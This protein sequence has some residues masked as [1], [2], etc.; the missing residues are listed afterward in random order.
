MI[1]D[2][3]IKYLLLN[4]VYF[5]R[6]ENIGGFTDASKELESL[7]KSLFS[8]IDKTSFDVSAV[9]CNN[10]NIEF[11]SND[12]VEFQVTTN[13]DFTTKCSDTITDFI[14]KKSSNKL[15]IVYYKEL[16]KKEQIKKNEFLNT[17]SFLEIVDAADLSRLIA[18]CS[19]SEIS[20]IVNE[21]QNFLPLKIEEIDMNACLQKQSVC[22]DF[23]ERTFN[24]L[25]HSRINTEDIVQTNNSVIIGDASTGKTELLKYINNLSVEKNRSTFFYKLKNYSGTKLKDILPNAVY[26]SFDPLIL[27]DGYDE[28]KQEYIDTF[29]SELN[30]LASKYPNFQIIISSRKNFCDKSFSP[31]DEFSFLYIEDIDDKEITQYFNKKLEKDGDKYIELCKTLNVYELLYNPFYLTRIVSAIKTNSTI[32]NRAELMELVF[33]NDYD[34]FK[35]SEN[36]KK[37]DLL[38]KLM[39]FA[40][41]LV[42][43]RTMSVPADAY[44]DINADDFKDFAWLLFEDGN[45]SFVHNNFKEYLMAKKMATYSFGKIKNIIS[46]RLDKIY[47]KPEYTSILS[48][49]LSIDSG[50]KLH[51]YILNYGKHIILDLEISSLSSEEKYKVITG[52]YGEYEKKKSWPDASFYKSYSL[53]K[54]CNTKRII[55]FLISK[56]DIANHRTTVVFTLEILKNINCWFG[57]KNTLERNIYKMLNSKIE[58]ITM[59][60]SLIYFWAKLNPGIE[61]V[62][63]IYLMYRTHEKSS[64]RASA[65]YLLKEYKLGNKFVEEMLN[66]I[67][68]TIPIA[69]A[70]G[71]K[72][73][74]IIDIGE[75]MYLEQAIDL[76]DDKQAVVKLLDFLIKNEKS[77]TFHSLTEHIFNALKN[78]KQIDEEIIEKIYVLY[79]QVEFYDS[80]NVKQCIMDWLT[81]NELIENIIKRIVKD[82]ELIEYKKYAMLSCLYSEK[83]NNIYLD[84]FKQNLLNDPNR[85]MLEL[86]SIN[87]DWSSL[88]NVLTL[89]DIKVEEINKKANNNAYEERVKENFNYL[90]DKSIL[91]D[92]IHGIYVQSGK[93]TLNR[94]D[95]MSIRC[96]E[97]FDDR[98]PIYLCKLFDE[99]SI[100]ETEVF[101][102]ICDDW[103]IYCA[104]ELLQQSKFIVVSN[105]QKEFISNWVFDKVK[106]F[107]F[108]DSIS[109]NN[110][111]CSTSFDAI[112]CDYFIRKLDLAVDKNIL[113]QMICFVWDIRDENDFSQIEFIKQKIGESELKDALRL[114][115]ERGNLQSYPLQNRINYCINND[116]D[117]LLNCIINKLATIKKSDKYSY[118]Y[119]AC[120]N[121]LEKFNYLELIIPYYINFPIELKLYV[122]N[123]FY[124]NNNKAI[125]DIAKNDFKKNTCYSFMRTLMQFGDEDA[126][127]YYIKYVKKNKCLYPKMEYPYPSVK[128]YN[129][130]SNLKLLFKLLPL[131]YRFEDDENSVRNDIMYCFEKICCNSNIFTMRKFLRKINLFIKHSKYKN[132]NYLHYY[133]DGIILSYINS[134]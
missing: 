106:K 108:E 124:K 60:S 128:S 79:K 111:K 20:A 31:F 39:S 45:I 101:S 23:I 68:N 48:F 113:K 88:R 12:G 97:V 134:K 37:Q 92:Q 67:H 112:L 103:Q 53:A 27:L 76:I 96:K 115:C 7:T 89:H 56:I 44:T 65:N 78:I 6:L 14:N 125:I 119:N 22:N 85:M 43:N 54:I 9:K 30:S 123:I 116:Y 121:Y 28:I 110:D 132:V 13:Q 11:I 77:Y 70:L 126:L 42:I 129:K 46:V 38:D 21:C 15:K 52:I 3:K 95:V 80:N 50:K 93:N 117:I 87:K 10:P 127:K 36:I 114:Y 18:N 90:F 98:F 40:E 5:C 24:W 131:T 86:K 66:S 71:E 55:E 94:E 99:I 33:N 105:F 19:T 118:E 72:E 26:Y 8:I 91:K 58:D 83:Y 120:I 4:I 32:T 73:Q 63:S 49:L 74:D 64:V 102:K 84:I 69:Y 57:Y 17:Y 35:F 34:K 100:T 47:I 16:V 109:Y 122:L 41:Y 81:T 29:V 107:N 133:V 130:K 59:L 82:S 1:H 2:N 51:K 61:D 25:D 62:C 75:N 104:Y